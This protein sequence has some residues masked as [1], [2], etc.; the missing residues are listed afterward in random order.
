MSTKLCKLIISRLHVQWNSAK[1]GA[2]TKR[3]RGGCVHEKTNFHLSQPIFKNLKPLRFW[4][5]SA[6]P[7]A[8]RGLISRPRQPGFRPNGKWFFQRRI[9]RILCAFSELLEQIN[10]VSS[11]CEMPYK[12]R[13][14]YKILT[15][16]TSWRYYGSNRTETQYTNHCG[17]LCYTFRNL[18]LYLNIVPTKKK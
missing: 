8:K 1:V 2:K 17:N 11:G 14:K 5:L 16:R 9:L 15:K 18:S 4:G 12:M 13:T 10:D 7:Q 6:S 3:N